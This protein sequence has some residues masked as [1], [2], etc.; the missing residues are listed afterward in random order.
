MLNDSEI[1]NLGDT[2][3]VRELKIKMPSVA[4]GVAT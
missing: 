4:R 2:A 3:Y 1:A